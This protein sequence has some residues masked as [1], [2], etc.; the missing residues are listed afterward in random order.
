[1]L[2]Y[3]FYTPPPPFFLSC[4]FSSGLV[5]C[6]VVIYLNL[7][8]ELMVY[9]GLLVCVIS[10]AHNVDA[11]IQNIHKIEWSILCDCAKLLMLKACPF[12]HAL[13]DLWWAIAVCLCTDTETFLVTSDIFW[14][15]WKVQLRQAT[16]STSG[17]SDCKKNWSCWDTIPS[18]RAWGRNQP[19]LYKLLSV[20]QKIW[21]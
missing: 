18:V 19:A 8:L 15:G 9:S 13:A 7:M 14:W 17:D 1:M 5:F 3:F 20:G 4:F 12:D 16:V 2:I 21:I 10:L 6:S 11:P